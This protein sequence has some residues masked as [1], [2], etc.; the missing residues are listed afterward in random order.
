MTT[1]ATASENWK[2][3]TTKQAFEQMIADSESLR[4]SAEFLME[5]V[6]RHTEYIKELKMIV[7]K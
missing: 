3:E 2:L 6:R 1:Q 4:Q 7:C 5:E